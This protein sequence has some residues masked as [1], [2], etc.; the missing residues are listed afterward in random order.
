MGD[1]VRLVVPALGFVIWFFTAWA[2]WRGASTG[3]VPG[4]PSGWPG[5]YRRKVQPGAY[6]L[7]MGVYALLFLWITFSIAKRVLSPELAHH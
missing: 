1:L 7:A 5:T 4:R 6:W 3:V 2:L